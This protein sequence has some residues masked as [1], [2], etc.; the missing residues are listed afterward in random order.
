MINLNNFLIYCKLDYIKMEIKKCSLEKHKEKQANSYCIKCEKY[1]CKKCELL[2]TELFELK[3]SLFI[4]EASNFEN[5]NNNKKLSELEQI[6]LEENIKYLKEFSNM[7]KEK[8]DILKNEFEK[9]E[10]IMEEL[11]MKIQKYFTKIRNELSQFEDEILQ[12]IDNRFLKLQLNQEIKNN[13]LLLNKIKLVLNKNII[14]LD[15]LIN[16]CKNYV[17][18]NKDINNHNKSIDL[19]EEGEIIE[20]CEKIKNLNK[21]NLLFNSSI[22]KNDLNK[23]LIIDNWI[24]EI[25]DKNSLKYNLIFKMSENGSSCSDFHKYCD[26]K[27]P[28][29]ILIKS[30]SN[31]IFGG[32]TPLKWDDGNDYDKNKTTFVF[33]LNLMKKFNMKNKD[34]RAIYCYESYGPIFGDSNSAAIYFSTSLEKGKSYADEDSNYLPF[35]KLELTNGIGNYEDFDTKEIEVFEVI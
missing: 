9:K 18:D 33:S 19:P 13:E 11:S 28:T 23:Q 10:K 30:T 31:K 15:P 12:E 6:T 32:F 14:N 27:A 26:N 29:L 34:K 8:N 24:K 1:M 5:I 4:Y 16:E 35:N 21:S 20:I 7:L 3:H 17:F 25:M 22:I 2:H